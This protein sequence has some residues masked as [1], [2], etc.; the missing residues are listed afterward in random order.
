MR[1]HTRT[2]I[3]TYVYINTQKASLADSPKLLPVILFLTNAGGEL[4][5]SPDR[6]NRSWPRSYAQLRF[7]LSY[8]RWLCAFVEG[9]QI[10][11]PQKMEE[12]TKR[13][14]S[15]LTSKRR[16]PVEIR[17]SVTENSASIVVGFV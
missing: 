11:I 9:P 10:K 1:T 12:K 8:L 2:N 4:S 13:R 15:G 17:G 3:Y 6:C 14:K 16:T 7:H 5:G